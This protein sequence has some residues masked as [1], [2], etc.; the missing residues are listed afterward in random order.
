MMLTNNLQAQRTPDL[1]T[2]ALI[3]DDDL[4]CREPNALTEQLSQRSIALAN[5]L[6]AKRNSV[7]VW[8]GTDDFL[9]ALDSLWRRAWPELR[10]ML[11]FSLAF[12][13]QDAHLDEYS[14]V[15]TPTTEANRWIGYQTLTE[16]ANPQSVSPAAAALAGGNASEALRDIAKHIRWPLKEFADLEHIASLQ[17]RLS[18]VELIALEEIRNLRLL[19]FLAPDVLTGSSLKSVFLDRAR[20]SI[21]SADTGEVLAC[22]NLTLNCFEDAGQFWAALA[23]RI[24]NSLKQIEHLDLS[25]FAE[26]LIKTNQESASPWKLSILNGMRN[27]LQSLSLAQARAI[28]SWISRFPE[29]TELLFSVLSSEKST[30]TML[31]ES[32]P[33]QGLEDAI[34]MVLRVIS[35][36]EMPFLL[37]KL[38]SSYLSVDEAFD[39][40]LTSTAGPSE[41]SALVQL[42]DSKTIIDQCVRTEDARLVPFA[43]TAISND[44]TLLMD[45]DLSLKGWRIVLIALRVSGIRFPRGEKFNLLQQQMLDLVAS[46]SVSEDLLDGLEELGLFDLSSVADNIQVWN[47]I[48]K[49]LLQR[50]VSATADPVIIRIGAGE[51][52][53]DQLAIELREKIQDR[54]RILR[55]LRNL[56][57]ARA[58]QLQLFRTFNQLTEQDFLGWFTPLLSSVRS[59][60]TSTVLAIGSLIA[61]RKWKV[62]AESAVGD[63]L[64]YK[65]TDLIPMLTEIRP[66]LGFK[67]AFKLMI[68]GVSTTPRDLSPSDFWL[69]LEV[70]LAERFPGGPQDYGLWSRS[71]GSDADLLTGVSGREQWR[72]ALRMIRENAH[73]SPTLDRLLDEVIKRFPYER[74]LAWFQ[75]YWRQVAPEA[76]GR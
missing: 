67:Q 39:W 11:T 12:T 29:T 45:A 55:V 8:S 22:R 14:V 38:S 66:L 71:K 9:P 54:P 42:Y 21:S 26:L 62:A 75:K 25:R 36:K 70:E 48:P 58:Q 64:D 51:L 28:W 27:G 31:E 52:R 15:Y 19:C 61:E 76:R 60:D 2:E 35:G 5:A 13:P 30:G 23:D 3:L 46:S 20:T 4:L 18:N 47:K 44:L 32:Y 33:K 73:E 74:S 1:N 68:A 56:V 53:V 10:Q 34:G 49:A 7:I 69:Q 16:K 57:G 59:L 37:A 50:L 43:K 41:L 63:I 17:E 72:H 6:V 40:Q 65:R 24:S